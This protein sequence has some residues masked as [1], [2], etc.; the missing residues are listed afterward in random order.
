MNCLYVMDHW[1]NCLLM[2]LAF[3]EI[4]YSLQFFA[5]ASDLPVTPARTGVTSER[6]QL[7]LEHS[8]T[9]I[10]K[11]CTAV[12]GVKP[13]RN[14]FIDLRSKKREMQAQCSA[15]NQVSRSLI[16][17]TAGLGGEGPGAAPPPRRDN[18]PLSPDCTE[19]KDWFKYCL[20]IGQGGRAGPGP[21]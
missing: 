8:K 21:G 17:L 9:Q 4:F 1:C 14:V 6:C 5:F 18:G 15:L 16:L 13:I 11:D 20:R 7:L 2:L 19:T 12:Y 10:R 3:I